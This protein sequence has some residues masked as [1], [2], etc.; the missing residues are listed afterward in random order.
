[1]IEAEADGRLVV[2]PC[3]AGDAIYIHDWRESPR[4][5][6]YSGYV[7]DVSV[8]NKEISIQ[9]K[10][11]GNSRFEQLLNWNGGSYSVESLGGDIFLS[12]EQ[13]EVALKERQG[14]Q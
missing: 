8:G 3:K 13:A 7:T 9:V 6:V 10:A 11:N 4:I 5:N 12:R 1:M 2:L 14:T